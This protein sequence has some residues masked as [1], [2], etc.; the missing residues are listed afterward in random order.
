MIVRVISPALRAA[1]FS[2]F[3]SLGLSA[4]PDPDFIKSGQSVYER[5]CA[6]C[7]KSSGEGIAPIFPPLTGSEWLTKDSSSLAI[8]IAL[9]GVEG[10]L[11]F[12]GKKFNG[13][14]LPPYGLS[15]E[16]VAQLVTFAASTFNGG[17][18][19]VTGMQ[20]KSVRDA[21]KERKRPFTAYELDPALALEGSL[22]KEKVDSTG[23]KI[24]QNPLLAGQLKR[25]KISYDRN[26]LICHA[27][28]GQGLPSLSPPLAGSEWV[29]MGPKVMVP[30]ILSGLEGPVV[31][32][33]QLYDASCPSIGE[34]S[35]AAIV[36]G[37][38]RRLA[39]RTSS[40]RP[41]DLT[42]QQSD[43]D[44]INR[45]EGEVADLVAYI[46]NSWGNKIGP[47][48]ADEVKEIRARSA[49]RGKPWTSEELKSKK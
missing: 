30:I 35:S 20:V 8:R 19:T 44:E 3:L 6:S 23:E 2:V 5:T 32:N 1:F 33:K 22:K 41:L 9:Y 18:A 46:G 42:T 36:A 49:E 40:K 39:D 43:I 14:C 48:S 12:E 17:T 29:A 37:R 27:A 10:P 45:I 11:R 31:V 47:V 16:E 26:C 34:W 28:K 15:D 24:E 7:H 21:N 38:L 4:K 13:P 25:G